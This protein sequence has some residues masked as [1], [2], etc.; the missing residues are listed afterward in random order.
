MGAIDRRALAV[1]APELS[2]E[3]LLQSQDDHAAARARLFAAAVDLL[4][5]VSRRSPL[6]VVIDDLQWADDASLLL[7]LLLRHATTRL[8]TMPVAVIGNLSGHEVQTNTARTALFVALTRAGLM[9]RLEGMPARDVEALVAATVGHDVDHDWSAAL[10]DR[11]GGNP[12]FATEVLRLLAAPAERGFR[13]T[14]ALVRD[15]LCE[16]SCWAGRRPTV[17]LATPLLRT[18]NQR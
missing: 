16:R 5:G 13:F 18:P 11:T 17:A 12:F 10:A 14:H 1:L 6:V 15:A 2:S 4:A 9:L 8:P 7:L 3:P